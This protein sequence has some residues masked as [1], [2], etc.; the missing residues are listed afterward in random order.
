MNTQYNLL[1]DYK[2]VI[3]TKEQDLLTLRDGILQHLTA[4]HSSK[5][6]K[7]LQVL[8]WKSEIE[9]SDILRALLEHNKRIESQFRSEAENLCQ[10][11]RDLGSYTRDMNKILADDLLEQHRIEDKHSID[12]VKNVTFLVATPAAFVTAVKNGLGDGLLNVYQAAGAGMILSSAIVS[13]KK[14]YKAFKEAGKNICA[15]PRQIRNSFMLYYM[16]EV[17]NEKKIA[18]IGVFR[19]AFMPLGKRISVSAVRAKKIG[20]LFSN[21]RKPKP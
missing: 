12:I 2:G 3:A 15:T 8:V 21:S 13:R 9:L 20:A 11:C 1:E 19:N 6:T 7:E 5:K 4:E 10:R 17:M 14:I 18:A 16:R